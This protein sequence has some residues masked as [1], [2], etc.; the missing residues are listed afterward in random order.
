MVEAGAASAGR[1]I[2]SLGMEGRVNWSDGDVE[3]LVDHVGRW[4][5]A[6]ATHISVNTMGAGFASVDEH[7][8]ALETTATALDLAAGTAP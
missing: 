2:A 6:G 4:R 3:R 7:L 1:D 5:G 8:A